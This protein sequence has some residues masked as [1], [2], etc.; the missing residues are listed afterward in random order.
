M[1]VIAALL[2]VTAQ[3]ASLTAP[4][5]ASFEKGRLVSLNAGARN[6]WEPSIGAD[7]RGNVVCSWKD[8]PSG[9]SVIRYSYSSDYGENWS[10]DKAFPDPKY[11]FQSD[12][13]VQVGNDRRFTLSWI[14]YNGTSDTAV[15]MAVSKDGGKTFSEPTK[16]CMPSK[17][18]AKDFF[19]RQWIAV[20]DD[21]VYMSYHIMNRIYVARST[22]GGRTVEAATTPDPK[23]SGAISA[24]ITRTPD[25]GVHTA[26]L[27]FRRKPTIRY[28]RSNDGAKTWTTPKD[29]IVMNALDF[30]GRAQCFS[31][32]GNDSMGNLFV[33][34][35]EGKGRDGDKDVAGAVYLIRSEDGG[36]KWTPP[37]KISDSPDEANGFK[38]QPWIYVD[39]QDRIHLT[40]LERQGEKYRAMYALSADR[41]ATFS[42]SVAV[43]SPHTIKQPYQSDFISVAS[44]D[45]Y[46][47]VPVPIPVGD[48]YQMLVYRAPVAGMAAPPVVKRAGTN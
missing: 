35:V 36:E 5:V 19:D 31:T 9:S 25:G 48:Y 30:K 22:D 20:Y 15:N 44:D 28:S 41:G 42:R 37:M 40:W 21:V 12:P 47:Y 3:S 2:A 43:S 38:L 10:Q 14:A 13:V 32:I 1:L 46:V 33:A 27:Q 17:E 11:K 24:V 8:G 6:E 23:G 4:P 16:I 29:L 34:W 7:G 39:S 45:R 26:W 18:G